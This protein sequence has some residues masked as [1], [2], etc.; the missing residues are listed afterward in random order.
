MKDT[1]RGAETQAEEEAGS[2]QAA[3]RGA[4]SRGSRIIPWAQGR[5]Q[6]AEPPRDSLVPTFKHLVLLRACVNYLI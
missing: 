1:E 2:M 5:R 4:W 6:T 3:Q